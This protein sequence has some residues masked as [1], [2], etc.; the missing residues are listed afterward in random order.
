LTKSSRTTFGALSSFVRLQL[1]NSV[2]AKSRSLLELRRPEYARC[3]QS[4]ASVCT[5]TVTK[6]VAALYVSGTVG[7][8]INDTL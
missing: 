5:E 6:E 7:H 8:D 1:V 3:R 4:L 2:V